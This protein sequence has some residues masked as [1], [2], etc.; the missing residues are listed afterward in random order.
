MTP[1]LVMLLWTGKEKPKKHRLCADDVATAGP[2]AR[3]GLLGRWGYSE[4][5][6][7]QRPNHLTL[8]LGAGKTLLPPRLGSVLS[9]ERP[10]LG[11]WMMGS[12]GNNPFQSWNGPLVL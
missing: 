7:T 5:A 2:A 11:S 8:W 12:D 1:E 10:F 3:T 6:S 9:S 4:G